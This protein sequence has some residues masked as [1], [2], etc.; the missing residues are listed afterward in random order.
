[1]Y[2]TTILLASSIGF[3]LSGSSL[4][5]SRDGVYGGIGLGGV[6]DSYS[7][8]LNNL[9][10]GGAFSKKP[11]E[12]SFLGGLFLGYGATNDLGFYLAGEIGTYLPRRSTTVNGVAG[13][14]PGIPTFNDRLRVKDLV[15]F[16]LLPG[17][18]FNETWLLYVRTG[19]SFSQLSFYQPATTV[20]TID[21]TENKVGGRIGLGLNYALTNNVG[22]GL[23]YFYTHYQELNTN[24]FGI[25][26][27]QKLSSNYLGI[28]ALYTI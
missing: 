17:Y 2:K 27:N 22:I 10:T 21:E 26:T 7:F 15:T 25:D 14:Y 3:L 9:S 6:S 5:S 19:L 8:R 16:D 28:S 13:I 11:T 23:D 24:Q 1:M 4:A 12:K 18:R 20:P